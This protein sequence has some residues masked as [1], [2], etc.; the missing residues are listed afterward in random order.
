MTD[1][2][3]VPVVTTEAVAPDVAVVPAKESVLEEVVDFI[4]EE[5]HK[6]YEWAT[7]AP[8][9]V[10]PEVVAQPTVDAPAAE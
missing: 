7:D 6:V 3:V 10:E 9:A 8:V 2:V 4:K 5:A 1:E